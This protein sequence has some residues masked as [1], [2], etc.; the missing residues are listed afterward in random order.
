MTNTR[1]TNK[2]TLRA[3]LMNPKKYVSESVASS[4]DV[5]FTIREYKH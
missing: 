4:D 5:N 3:K 2:L 1:C